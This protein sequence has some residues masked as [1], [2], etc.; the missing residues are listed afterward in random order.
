MIHLPKSAYT[1]CDWYDREMRTLFSNTWQF[2]GFVEDLADPG[3]WLTVQVGRHNLLVVKGR[4][5]RLRA[6]HNLC[7]HRG[8]QL[9]RATG[10]SEKAITCPYHRWTYSLNGELLSVPERQRE[11][12][13]LD[14]KKFCLHRASVET[15]LGMIWVHPKPDAPGLMH[16]L[17]DVPDH[18]GPHRPEELVP[19]PEGATDHEIAANWKIVV[20]NYID[21]YHLAHLHA[22]TLNMYWHARQESRF[23]GP[24]FV[25][26]EPLS[27]EYEANLEKMAPMPLIDHFT[28]EKP[29]GAYVPMLFPN[30]GIAANETMW[31]IFHVI[32]L[33]PDRTRVVTRTRVMPVSELAFYRQYLK[34]AQYYPSSETSGDD[35]LASGN[36]IDEDIYACEQ[37]QKSLASPLFS[38]GATAK[39]LEAAVVQFQEHVHAHVTAVPSAATE[40]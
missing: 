9:L 1:S 26:Y 37:Q 13:D 36:F 5:H 40:V 29:V 24:H 20:E 33:A 8:T 38:V 21:G 17:R 4:D 30:L 12:P 3:D 34:S 16:W 25:F 15:W 10:K 14:L 35:P 11:F 39:N 23:I 18:I 27:P 2:C 7:R 6:F 22:D 32:P 28:P 31:S 19:Y